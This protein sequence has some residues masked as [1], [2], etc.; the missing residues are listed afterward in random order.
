MRIPGPINYQSDS[1]WINSRSNKYAKLTFR[2]RNIITKT[3][4][5]QNQGINRLFQ[6]YQNLV[7]HLVSK[8]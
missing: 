1:Y 2:N 7:Y 6:K 8:I 5:P 3:S 4:Q